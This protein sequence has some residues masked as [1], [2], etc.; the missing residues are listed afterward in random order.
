MPDGTQIVAS[1]HIGNP[2]FGGPRRELLVLFLSKESLDK[3]A[4]QTKPNPY[5]Q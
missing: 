3:K 4:Q 5:Q 2:S 1:E